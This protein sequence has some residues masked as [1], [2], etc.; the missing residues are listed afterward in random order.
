MT[1]QNMI[2]DE[3]LDKAVETEIQTDINHEDSVGENVDGH[4]GEMGFL[5]NA[6]QNKIALDKT[7]FEC[8]KEIDI[9]KEK[10][11]VLHLQ[12]TDKGVVAFASICE[13][14]FNKIET[15]FKKKPKDIKAQEPEK[16]DATDKNVEQHKKTK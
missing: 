2:S 12:N 6:V 5:W 1:E 3:E 4:L 16:K 8:K 15:Q 13:E 10:P 11:R 14:C 9:K 7:C